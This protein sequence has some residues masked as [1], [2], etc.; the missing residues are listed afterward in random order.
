M[1]N[2]SKDES[3]TESGLLAKHNANIA[4]LAQSFGISL[5]GPQNIEPTKAKSKEADNFFS[6]GEFKT[7]LYDM[8]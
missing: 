8:A 5:E 7:K 2:K 6:Q 3:L 4:R 1:Y